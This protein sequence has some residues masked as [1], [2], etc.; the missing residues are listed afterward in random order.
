MDRKLECGDRV[1]QC[2]LRQ[3]SAYSVVNEGVMLI[4]ALRVAAPV[5]T[6]FI[7]PEYNIINP[8]LCC[9]QVSS[10]IMRRA[11]YCGPLLTLDTSANDL[12]LLLAYEDHIYY[13]KKTQAEPG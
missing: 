1:H 8:F 11:S 10:G 5:I 9:P 13:K 7:N 2:G 12:Y 6:G 4:F 3:S